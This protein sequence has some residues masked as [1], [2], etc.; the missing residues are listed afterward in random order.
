MVGTRRDEIVM[1]LEKTSSG[2]RGGGR[3]TSESTKRNIFGCTER[4]FL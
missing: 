2:E 3:G 4:K 1:T